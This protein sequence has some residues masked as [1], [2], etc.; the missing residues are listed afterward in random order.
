[1]FTAAALA[2]SLMRMSA[3]LSS[4]LRCTLYQ[5]TESRGP[6]PNG[7]RV[8]SGCIQSH[9]GLKDHE[10]KRDDQDKPQPGAQ[11]AGQQ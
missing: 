8:R 11:T 4:H 2:T 3:I 6:A 1:M 5:G 10:V 9:A 7:S